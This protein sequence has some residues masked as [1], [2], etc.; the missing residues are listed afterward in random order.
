MCDRFSDLKGVDAVARSMTG[1]SVDAVV[2]HD[3]LALEAA[4]LY[5]V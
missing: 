1:A 2:R 3:E 5:F 4:T